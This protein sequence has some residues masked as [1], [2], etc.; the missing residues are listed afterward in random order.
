MS[1]DILNFLSVIDATDRESRLVKKHCDTKAKLQQGTAAMKAFD[2]AKGDYYKLMP[3]THAVVWFAQAA[4]IKYLDQSEYANIKVW[5]ED[6][7][8]K[9]HKN[10]GADEEFELAREAFTPPD[11]RDILTSIY[12]GEFLQPPYN[13]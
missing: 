1:I 7:M 12:T 6:N 13:L 9:I 3:K 2:D 10:D 11:V 5:F 4:K 8:S